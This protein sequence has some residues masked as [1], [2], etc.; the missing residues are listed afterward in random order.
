M[1]DSQTVDDLDVVVSQSDSAEELNATL[2]IPDKASASAETSTLTKDTSSFLRIGEYEA[3]EE[4]DRSPE[5]MSAAARG[6]LVQTTGGLF[7]TIG[8]DAYHQYKGNVDVEIEGNLTEAITGDSSTTISGKSDVH[9]T[10]VARHSGQSF[11][12]ATGSYSNTNPDATN[13]IRLKSDNKVNLNSDTGVE[14]TVGSSYYAKINSEGQ[15]KKNFKDE[16]AVTTGT[17]HSR[18]GGWTT[19]EY[20]GGSFTFQIAFTISLSFS[21][22]IDISLLLSIAVS[23]MSVEAKGLKMEATKLAVSSTG[24]SVD[25]TSLSVSRT[26]VEVKTEDARVETTA[27]AVLNKAGI[28]LASGMNII[29]P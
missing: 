14:M 23:S 7:F 12:I 28:K 29:S 3:S 27:S 15:W 16:V 1:S 10:G 6:V 26:L 11:V 19:S 25:I 13:D 4:G 24:V 9:T 8:E 20:Y 5:N 17:T 18:Y 21:I 2:L 22:S